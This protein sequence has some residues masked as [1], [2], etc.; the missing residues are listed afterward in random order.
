MKNFG[1]VFQLSQGMPASGGCALRL[2]F[3]VTQ[4]GTRRHGGPLCVIYVKNE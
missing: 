1:D 2:I 3:A 4:P